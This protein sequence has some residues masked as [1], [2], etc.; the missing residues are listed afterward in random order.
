[1]DPGSPRLRRPPAGGNGTARLEALVPVPV[2]VAVAVTVALLLHS[3]AVGLLLGWDTVA[4][5]YIG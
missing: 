5:L 4:V 3:P 2:G 1:M